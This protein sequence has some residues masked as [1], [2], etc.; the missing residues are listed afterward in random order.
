[1][2]NPR[3]RKGRI[4]HCRKLGKIAR[5]TAMALHDKF[6]IRELDE[7]HG[8]FMY[9]EE[10]DA[11]EQV[12]K[13]PDVTVYDVEESRESTKRSIC[14]PHIN[15]DDKRFPKCRKHESNYTSLPRIN[16]Q[17]NNSLVNSSWL[18]IQD[19][20]VISWKK[21]LDV[22]GDKKGMPHQKPRSSEGR[23]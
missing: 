21:A 20:S 8:H 7:I 19:V 1:M 11:I 16:E 17:R 4:K 2:K 5:D 9:N 14:L 15:E 3:G 22:L 13:L 6:S 10:N 23:S 12:L 18:E